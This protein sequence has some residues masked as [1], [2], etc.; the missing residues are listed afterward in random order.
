MP[1]KFYVGYRCVWNILQAAHL[2]LIQIF[3][4]KFSKIYTTPVKTKQPK[5]HDSILSENKKTKGIFKKNVFNL[6]Y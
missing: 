6:N 3:Y 5:I 1:V 4:F 2:R